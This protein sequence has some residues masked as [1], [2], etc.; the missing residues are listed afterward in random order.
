[1]SQYKEN[2]YNIYFLYYVSYTLRDYRYPGARHYMGAHLSELRGIY[3]KEP[4]KINE[5][6]DFF[7]TLLHTFSKQQMD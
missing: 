1:M 7:R 6:E 4:G 5:R 3:R 2:D